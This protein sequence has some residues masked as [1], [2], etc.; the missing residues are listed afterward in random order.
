MP[1]AQTQNWRS[2]V[3]HHSEERGS[4]I[5]KVLKSAFRGHTFAFCFI[6]CLEANGQVLKTIGTRR[7]SRGSRFGRNCIHHRFAVP[8]LG[9]DLRFLR[10]LGLTSLL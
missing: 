7:N 6:N 9:N 2:P 8:G 5:C 4:E 3:L 10:K 1:A